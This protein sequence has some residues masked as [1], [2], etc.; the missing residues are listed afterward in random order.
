MF[1]SSNTAAVEGA[2]LI[3][4]NLSEG[5]C[6]YLRR[7]LPTLMKAYVQKGLESSNHDI[8]VAAFTAINYFAEFLVPEIIVFHEVIL[9]LLIKNLDDT[10]QKA[11]EGNVACLE[12]FCEE[13][14]EDIIN[15]I[16][17]LIPKFIDLIDKDVNTMQVKR[18]AVLAISSCARVAKEKFAPYAKDLVPLLA[19]LVN[20]NN[21][22]YIDLKATA[23]KCIGVIVASS[24]KE[25][26]EVF[27]AH[28]EPLVETIYLNL[29]DSDNTYLKECSL[30]FF[31]NLA[32]YLGPHFK[33]YLDKLVEIIFAIFESLENLQKQ[34][35][36]QIISLNPDDDDDED[37]INADQTIYEEVAAA[38][39]C[40]GEM[41]KACPADFAPYYEKTTIALQLFVAHFDRLIRE[42]S[43]KCYAS[44]TKAIVKLGNNG[45]LPKFNRGLPCG[46][47]FSNDAEQ[48]LYQEVYERFL[49]TLQMDDDIS[50][51][52]TI[53]EILHEFCNELGP[54]SVDLRLERITEQ[55]IK[56]FQNE[57]NAQNQAF[58]E[59][60]EVHGELFGAATFLVIDFIKTCGEGYFSHFQ[61]LYPE[62]KKFVSEDSTEDDVAEVIAC[63]SKAV[64]FM[65]VSVL[66]FAEE[67][68]NTCLEAL[69]F[70]DEYINQ[71]V[72]YCLGEI[73]EYGK[74]KVFPYY[75]TIF[76]KLRVIYDNS[77]LNHTRDNAI[78]SIA[79]MIYTNPNLVP[80]NVVR[81]LI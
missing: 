76:Q 27:K 9:P 14:N 51:L 59:G 80:T 5:C 78:A 56:I 36:A 75:D 67:I 8:K 66:S 28:V 58:E 19:Q 71:N 35:P 40:L 39:C 54:A 1:E 72:A 52:V 46:Q 16:P 65:P 63:F 79:R 20:L 25:N 43:L 15:Y 69:N 61:R 37:L 22:Q 6:E 12:I 3:L 57:T 49:T 23:S 41:A 45:E 74:D 55:L 60:E 77:T 2:F 70:G 81:H 11:L 24:L 18:H 13:M 31:Y 48:F 73:V 7:E 4:G 50:I 29:K 26:P 47:R 10:N 68:L 64:K 42:Q 30:E 33:P 34:K 62:L 32:F 53:L 38:I 21:A 17:N 44:L